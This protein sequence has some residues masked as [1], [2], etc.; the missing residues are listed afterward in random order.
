VTTTTVNDG[1][2][3]AEA[4]GEDQFAIASAVLATA[5]TGEANRIASTGQGGTGAPAP[6]VVPATINQAAVQAAP[7]AVNP[8]EVVTV[9][10]A[11]STR[12]VVQPGARVVFFGDSIT[13]L[14]GF[15][16]GYVSLI[17]QQLAARNPIATVIDAGVSGNT[18][19]D[20]QARL[21][22]DVLAQKPTLVVIYI[23]VNDV[24][25]NAVPGGETPA[26]YVAGLREII[27]KVQAT[28]AD[29][30]LCTPSVIGERN[31]GLNGLDP[32][33]DQ[34]AGLSRQVAAQTRVSLVDLHEA[35]RTY[36]NQ[37]NTAEQFD[38]ILTVSGGVHLNAAGNQFV[39]SQI[40]AMMQF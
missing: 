37:Y 19:P 8:A 30:L 9:A 32:T 20:L 27:G 3:V 13:Y 11:L 18:V 36:E 6:S 38:G 34:F 28:G 2:A 23:G 35:F 5:K 10:T 21:D 25:S 22:R 7:P 24:R 17:G 26:Q 14:G 31:D 29:V 1:G 33:L 16:G 4:N 39:A 15:A 40:L 12:V